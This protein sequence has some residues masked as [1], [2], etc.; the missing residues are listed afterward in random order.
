MGGMRFKTGEVV[1][2]AEACVVVCRSALRAPRGAT[3]TAAAEN[4]RH[5]CQSGGSAPSK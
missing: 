2:R 5:W 4:A 1:F 3:T